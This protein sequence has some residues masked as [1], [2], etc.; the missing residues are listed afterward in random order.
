MKLAVEMSDQCRSNGTAQYRHRSFHSSALCT[1]VKTRRL[2][3]ALPY[4]FVVEGGEEQHGYD[5]DR[6]PGRPP[7]TVFM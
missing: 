2:A 6:F 3:K 7:I 5:Y 1:H 4:A